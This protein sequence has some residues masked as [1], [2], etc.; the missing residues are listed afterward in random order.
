MRFC[1][2]RLSYGWMILFVHSSWAEFF[3][4]IGWPLGVKQ[5]EATRDPL[6]LAPPEVEMHW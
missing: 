5:W 1:H 4:D 2:S 3:T 6:A